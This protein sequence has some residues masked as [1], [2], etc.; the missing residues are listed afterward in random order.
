VIAQPKDDECMDERKSNENCHYAILNRKLITEIKPKIAGRMVL[1][2]QMSRQG[3][4][5]K[6]RSVT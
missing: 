5:I 6:L 3:N 1:I 4:T 2:N